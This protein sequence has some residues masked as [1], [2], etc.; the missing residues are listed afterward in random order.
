MLWRRGRYVQRNLR[1]G[2]GIGGIMISFTNLTEKG[3]IDT[4]IKSWGQMKGVS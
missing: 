1:Y 3:R 2:K 4:Q